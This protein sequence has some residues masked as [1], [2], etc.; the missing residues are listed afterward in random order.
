MLSLFRQSSFI[1]LIHPRL[2]TMQLPTDFATYTQWSGIATLGFFGLTI[3]AFLFRWGLRFRLVGTT[4]FMG[5]LT[6]GLFGL[7]LGLFSRE[8]VPGAGRYALV[9]DNAAANVVIAVS[10][11]TTPNELTA[12]LTQ[13]AID[14][15]PYGRLGAGDG[16]VTIR[17]RAVTHPEPGLSIPLYL[18]QAVKPSGS[19]DL[20]DIK[21]ELFRDR[22]A[23]LPTI[24]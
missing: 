9:Y 19:R 3:L 5:V 15:A 13:A 22:F 7:N 21:I 16:N 2:I 8:A 18:G 14:I 1:H 17:A 11:E 4:A 12:T 6:V 20:A 23:Q 10:S 24:D